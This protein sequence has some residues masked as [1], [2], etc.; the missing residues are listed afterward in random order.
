MHSTTSYSAYQPRILIRSPSLAF[1]LLSFK[2]LVLDRL[3]RLSTRFCFISHDL[4][5]NVHAQKSTLSPCL[6]CKLSREEYHQAQGLMILLS[7]LFGRTWI[8]FFE[9]I[10]VLLRVYSM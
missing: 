4:H 5:H 7:L 8:F 2:F 3:T 6:N 10:F 9:S 1:L